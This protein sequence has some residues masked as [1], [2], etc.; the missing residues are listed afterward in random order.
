M[1]RKCRH[2]VSRAQKQIG[3]NVT[4]NTRVCQLQQ[5]RRQRCNERNARSEFIKQMM[6]VRDTEPKGAEDA[7]PHDI[8]MLLQTEAVIEAQHDQAAKYKL[9]CDWP[10]EEVSEEHIFAGWVIPIKNYS[11]ICQ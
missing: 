10:H 7:Q 4:E 5:E 2:N 1:T 8:H 11:I 3:G 9:F 6:Q